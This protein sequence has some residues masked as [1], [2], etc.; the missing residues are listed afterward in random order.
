M[1]KN[2]NV[3]RT[4]VAD[5]KGRDLLQDLRVDEEIILKGMLEIVD[6][7]LWSAFYWLIVVT[8]GGLL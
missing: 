6:R 1:R 3:I 2:R 5:L 7:V 8:G 4:L